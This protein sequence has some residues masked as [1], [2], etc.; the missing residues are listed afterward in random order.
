MTPIEW[1]A[2]AAT[3]M[4]AAALILTFARFLMGPSVPDRALA[5][6]LMAMTGLSLA[7]TL[8]VASG[9]KAFLDVGIVIA[10]LGFFTAVAIARR[11]E[12]SN[13]DD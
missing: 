1:G 10:L 7:V 8:S 13:A 3:P 12:E 6:E 2:W 11:L 5:L 4:L 9:V